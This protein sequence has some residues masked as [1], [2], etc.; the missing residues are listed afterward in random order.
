[1]NALV[2]DV[3]REAH[4]SA[5][6]RGTAA[7]PY[8]I[9]T[10]KYE[11]CQAAVVQTQR[12]PLG[13]ASAQIAAA[14]RCFRSLSEHRI[15]CGSDSGCGGVVFGSVFST[16]LVVRARKCAMHPAGP[17]PLCSRGLVRNPD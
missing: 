2:P 10:Y 15:L 17:L 5:V 8:Q 6:P 16:G 13:V 9:V 7:T 14:Q 12:G 11:L 4:R 1:M 3:A